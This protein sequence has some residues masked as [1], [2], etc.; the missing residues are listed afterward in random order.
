MRIGAD[1]MARLAR[2][3]ILSGLPPA[4]T[5]ACALTL[6][7]AALL[8]GRPPRAA[9]T[10]TLS[11]V[12]N[13]AATD[14]ASSS[15]DP[16][17][18]PAAQPTTPYP[19]IKVAVSPLARPYFPNGTDFIA[20]IVPASTFTVTLANLPVLARPRR[21]R[22]PELPPQPAPAV[23][24]APPPPA[25]A[26][27]QPVTPAPPRPTQPM[28]FTEFDE[29]LRDSAT[30]QTINVRLK[31]SGV[32]FRATHVGRIGDRAAVR[33]AIANEESSDFF[34]SIVN[35]WAND[36]PVR[37]ETA[38]PY[39]CRSGQ[40]IFGVLHFAAGDAVGKK[41]KVELV[42][43]GGERRRFALALDYRF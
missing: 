27:A 17:L 34:L 18:V 23:V 39:A 40:E 7:G 29:A 21:E 38:G 5:A 36:A 20:R 24:Q 2:G 35:V 9:A 8:V 26:P 6:C 33:F 1:I 32:S 15:Q 4:L 14:G 30:T 42:Q 16:P 10:P 22:K 25:M 11:G 31:H 28:T 41:V 13:S 12:L 3:Q 19:E 37:S 43:S